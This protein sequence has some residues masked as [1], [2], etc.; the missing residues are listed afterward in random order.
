MDYVPLKC[1]PMVRFALLALSFFAESVQARDV[2]VSGYTRN[3][4]TYVAPHYRSAPDGSFDNNW[5]TL[6]NINPHTGRLGTLTSPDDSYR[7]KITL[8]ASIGASGQGDD[9]EEDYEEDY[10]DD[11]SEESPIVLP[12][13]A[14][15][16]VDGSDWECEQGYNRSGEGCVAVHPPYNAK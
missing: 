16:T 9:Y 15:L 10:E 7:G 8:P 5:S 6:G 11:E 2:S 12:V 13:N 4:G 3:D 1:M 14:R